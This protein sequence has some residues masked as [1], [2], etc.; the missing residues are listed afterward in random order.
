MEAGVPQDRDSLV[1]GKHTKAVRKSQKMLPAACS[2]SSAPLPTQGPRCSP[3][4]PK[5][6]PVKEPSLRKGEVTKHQR[7]PKR[8]VFARTVTTTRLHSGARARPVRSGQACPFSLALPQ[9]TVGGNEGG[10]GMAQFRPH[11]EKKMFKLGRKRWSPCHQWECPGLSKNAPA[12]QELAPG[13]RRRMV[14]DGD[15]VRSEWA[16]APSLHREPCP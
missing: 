15:V 3:P 12:L 6:V 7:L 13:A 2:L 8:C 11:E 9:H 5:E 1:E 14:L 10:R 4:S 16:C